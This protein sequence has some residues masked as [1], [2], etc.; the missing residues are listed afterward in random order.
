M[1]KAPTLCRGLRLVSGC[2]DQPADVS[3]HCVDCTRPVGHV[4]FDQ[5]TRVSL[6]LMRLV[7][8]RLALCR[9]ASVR[10]QPL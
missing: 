3:E 10:L 8:L 6:A 1:W 2:A 5:V 7:Y 9:P 4:V